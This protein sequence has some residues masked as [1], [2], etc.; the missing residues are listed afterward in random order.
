MCMVIE[1][2]LDPEL[3]CGL[4]LSPAFC[5]FSAICF[6]LGF[7]SSANI[8][9]L[10]EGEIASPKLVK[11]LSGKDAEV[12]WHPQMRVFFL[13]ILNNCLSWKEI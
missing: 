9:Y 10:G 3:P 8:W 11:L 1:T 2:I 4:L 12:S 5:F 7:L 6:V 13:G